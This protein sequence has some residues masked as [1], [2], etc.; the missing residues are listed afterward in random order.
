MR[1]VS[2]ILLVSLFGFWLT[3][4]AFLTDGQANL[5]ACCR[6]GGKHHCAMMDTAQWALP[7]NAPQVL[8]ARCPYFPRARAFP[9]HSGTALVAASHSVSGWILNEPA[10][11]AQ[12]GAGYRVAFSRAHQKRGPPTMLS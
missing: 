3:G 4:P 9:P 8:G 5:P 10:V 2:A 12:A 7:G 6:R 1:R 11:P